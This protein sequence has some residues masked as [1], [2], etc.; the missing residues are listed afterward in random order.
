MCGG[1]FPTLLPFPLV[2]HLSAFSLLPT[3]VAKVY[4]RLRNKPTPIASLGYDFG[5][6]F[7]FLF[8]FGF[9]FGIAIAIGIG[10][11]DLYWVRDL[12]PPQYD[13]IFVIHQHNIFCSRFFSLSTTHIYVGH[14]SQV[15]AF[16]Y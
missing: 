14:S 4:E 15:N 11:G 2:R 16:I 10:I 8:G 12:S 3:S 5:F 9:G 13:S 7:R 1:V 6:G